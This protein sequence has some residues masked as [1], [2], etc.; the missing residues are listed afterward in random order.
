MPIALALFALDRSGSITQSCLKVNK[1]WQFNNL[2]DLL[3]T[4]ALPGN[5]DRRGRT[6]FYEPDYRREDCRSCLS[7]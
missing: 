2:N 5:A 6:S 3:V 7:Y 1:Q 4:F